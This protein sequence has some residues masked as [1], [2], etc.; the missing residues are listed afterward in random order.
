MIY[1]AHVHTCT[2]E[3]TYQYVHIP[4]HPSCAWALTQDALG[5][6][7]YIYISYSTV[8]TTYQQTE[9]S[10]DNPTDWAVCRQSNR[11]SCLQTIQQT[12]LSADNVSPN[13]CP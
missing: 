7:I 9:L 6:T 1:T 8:R 10:A 5:G 4:C 2:G 13:C 11:L 3:D 12:G